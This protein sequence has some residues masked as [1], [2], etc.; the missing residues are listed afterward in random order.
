LAI[1]T[2]FGEIKGD[3]E[4]LKIIADGYEA[5]LDKLKTWQGQAEIT[6]SVSIGS[7]QEIVERKGRYKADF[8]IDRTRD[9][10]RWTWFPIE[11]IENE[12]GQENK[13]VTNPMAGMSKGECDY[14]LFY[15]GYGQQGER[16]NLNIYPRDQWPRNFEGIG[17][18]PVHILEKEIYPDIVGQLRYYH[19][20]GGKTVHSN[21]RIIR[22]GDIVTFETDNDR[23]GNYGR[24]ITRFVFD[25]SKGCSLREFFTSSR[26]SE[27][28]WKLDYEKIADV[29]VIKSVYHKH[30]DKRQASERNATLINTDVN[31]PIDETEFSLGRLGLKSGDEIKDT[32]TNLTYI[33][34]EKRTTEA[35]MPPK[36]IESIKD[37]EIPDF[38]GI[39]IEFDIEQPKGKMLLICF[40]DYQQRPSRNCIIQLAK[41]AQGL[42]G[43]NVVVIAIQKSK[44][45]QAKLDEWIKENNI[46]FSVGTIQTDEE[47][48]RFTWGVKSFPWLILT[49]KK[50]IVVNEGFGLNELEQKI[51]GFE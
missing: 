30:K 1:Q 26:V 5:N 37:K 11:E 16:R 40:F 38:K 51:K 36:M 17:F 13:S 24:I 3:I 42:K 27:G 46:V 22:N 23:G 6:S 10:I 19:Q 25:L 49:D 18:D 2:C 7:G 39:D 28:H 21:G 8:L 45:E 35:D 41:Q 31:K 14:V 9:A 32:R 20:L 15:S 43:K 29:F 33:F 12:E 4:L 47:Q 44:I 48:M 34:G 50:H